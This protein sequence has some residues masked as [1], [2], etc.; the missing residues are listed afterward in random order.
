[1]V[2]R[3]V[4]GKQPEVGAAQ[5]IRGEHILARIPALRDMVRQTDGYYPSFPRHMEVVGI[6]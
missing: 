3:R 4:L 5:G 1:M 2:G 6:R